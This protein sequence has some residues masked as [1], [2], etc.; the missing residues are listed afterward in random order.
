MKT[1]T[2][3]P[4]L[5][6]NDKGENVLVLRSALNSK[7]FTNT[8]GNTVFDKKLLE[9]VTYFQQTNMDVSGKPLVTDG[10][11]G[12]KTWGSLLAEA[13]T[14]NAETTKPAL[15]G[16]S[17]VR[18]DIIN[19]AL[20]DL[21]K[22]VREIPNGSNYGGGVERYLYNVGPQAWCC[23]AVCEWF[24]DATGHF[25]FGKRTGRVRELRDNAIFASR[26]Y[27]KA[28]NIPVPGDAFVML[29]RNS[30][31]QLLG[32]GHTGIII[33]TS[34]SL[35]DFN[36][37]EGNISNRVRMMTRSVGDVVLDGYVDLVGD[38]QELLGQFQL[39]LVS[40]AE[41]ETG[42]LASTR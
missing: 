18:K 3:L 23:Y 6:L 5:R 11:V 26:Y 7:G 4:V 2:K 37:V 21:R 39:G 14:R 35:E 33:A 15:R 34:T 27:P 8:P 31:G 30:R 25:P 10:I 13:D 42:T 28:N 17:K 36:A 41:R 40:S 32:T 20:A 12:A 9:V 19:A 1:K 16:L 38:R 22:N 29:Y 24:K